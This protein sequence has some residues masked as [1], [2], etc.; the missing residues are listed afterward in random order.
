MPF[1][2]ARLVD[3][4]LVVLRQEW[5]D[6]LSITALGDGLIPSKAEDL[7]GLPPSGAEAQPMFDAELVAMHARATVNIRLE[8]NSLPF[9]IAL[10]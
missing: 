9:P 8:G 7:A 1:L 5:M 2:E 10:R 6:E 3:I 4:Q